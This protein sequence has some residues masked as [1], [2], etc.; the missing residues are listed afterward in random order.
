MNKVTRWDN[1]VKLTHW[2][3]AF[4]FFI[5]YFI[6]KAG[7]EVHQWVG[8]T[9]VGVVIIRLLWGL[10]AKPPARLS[11]FLPS[12]PKA[13]EHVLEVASTRNDQHQGHNPAGAIMIWCMWSGLLITGL[14]GYLL[15]AHLFGSH[16]LLKLIHVTAVNITFG[17]VCV[18]ICAVIVMSQITSRSYIKEMLPGQNKQK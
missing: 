5:N 13:I 7:S 4:L 8:Y 18:H 14:S 3:V 15:E 11:S 9:L 2:I 16:H 17:C 6:T 12:I 1:V 10:I